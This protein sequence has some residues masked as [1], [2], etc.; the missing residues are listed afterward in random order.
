MPVKIQDK[1][2]NFGENWENFSKKR[3]SSTKIQEAKK[4]FIK[5]F[6][7]ESIKNKTFIDIGFGQGLSLLIANNMC[8]ITVGN[9]INPL[10]EKV[11]EFNKHYFP[12]IKEKSIPIIIGSILNEST[13]DA[14]RQIN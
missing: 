6:Q 3:L 8:A 13:L 1:Q 2:F 11:L 9:D 5:F 12:D 7:N 14:I 10:N 4:G